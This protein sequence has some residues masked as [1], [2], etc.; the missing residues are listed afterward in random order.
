[1]ANR[2]TDVDLAKGNRLGGQGKNRV[3][4]LFFAVDSW[5]R[6]ADL[7]RSGKLIGGVKS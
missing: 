2:L 6:S 1:V 4:G 7:L 3:P 5:L